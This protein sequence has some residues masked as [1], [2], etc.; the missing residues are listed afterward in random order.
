MSPATSRKSEKPGSD[1]VVIEIEEK[2]D[3]VHFSLQGLAALRSLK[4]T[5]SGMCCCVP[6]ATSCCK[7][8]RPAAEH[9]PEE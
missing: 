2:D 5:F 3:G 4:E 9:Q 8:D 1:K 7:P 6:A